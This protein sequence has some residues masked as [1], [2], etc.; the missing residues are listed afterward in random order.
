MNSAVAPNKKAV[1][2]DVGIFA[3]EGFT[4][5]IFITIREIF[6]RFDKMAISSAILSVAQ[7]PTSDVVSTDEIIQKKNHGISINEL[8]ISESI[9][10]NPQAY[11][12]SVTRLLTEYQPAVIFMNTPAVFFE[13]HHTHILQTVLD[14]KAKLIMI[15]ADSLYPT[16]AKHP[17]K[18][19]KKYYDLLK[20]QI[21]IATSQTLIDQ[22]VKDTGLQAHYFP[23]IFSPLESH[24]SEGT[25]DH[26]TLVNHHPVKG[27]EIF[28]AIARKMP[29]K[30]FLIVETW[31]DVPPYISPSD[32]VE[33]SKFIPD[34]R[35][36]Y[37]K[38][39]ILLIPSLY[40]EGPARI[41][42]E[43]MLNGIPVIAHRIG[44]LPEVGKDYIF[45]VEPPVID[46][47]DMVGTVLYPRVSTTELD[48][49]TDAFVKLIRTIDESPESW[50][51]Q[52]KRAKE[53]AEKYCQ[54]VEAGFIEFVDEWFK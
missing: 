35:E 45:L 36:L 1:F 9:E 38:T 6:R 19:V 41:I 34:V 43:A 5:G 12:N 24:V 13:A 17:D 27:R 8:L 30:K 25:H 44:C 29:D 23:N 40:D 32:N 37:K 28:D 31:P 42:T 7:A 16:D 48:R 54:E 11:L 50:A 21:I 39:R 18:D 3:Q 20:D 33:F 47:T 22:F 26:I 15:L 53:Y 51:T 46:R 52:S 14:S 2:L 4:N 49:V 10:E